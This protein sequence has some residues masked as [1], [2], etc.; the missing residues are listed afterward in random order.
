[1][2]QAGLFDSTLQQ[3]NITSGVRTSWISVPSITLSREFTVALWVL[4][5]SNPATSSGAPRLFRFASQVSPN[6]VEAAASTN[7]YWCGLL[8]QQSLRRG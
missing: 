8:L 4:I 6:L 5:L 2:Q 1:M 7:G 3:F